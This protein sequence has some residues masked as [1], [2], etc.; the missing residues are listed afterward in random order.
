MLGSAICTVEDLF[1]S[2]LNLLCSSVLVKKAVYF[3]HSSRIT[4]ISEQKEQARYDR[5]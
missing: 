4:E 5:T 3:Y 1:E 2:A